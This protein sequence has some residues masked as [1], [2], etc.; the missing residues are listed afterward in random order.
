MTHIFHCIFKSFYIQLS[1]HKSCNVVLYLYRHSFHVFHPL[2]V[3]TLIISYCFLFVSVQMF[4]KNHGRKRKNIQGNVRFGNGADAPHTG[5][6]IINLIASH[7]LSNRVSRQVG[8][9]S[10]TFFQENDWLR[11][12]NNPT[13]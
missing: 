5:T 2:F 11:L 4:V 12:V 10:E 7:V 6:Y 9:S 8:L 1:L 3:I 13:L